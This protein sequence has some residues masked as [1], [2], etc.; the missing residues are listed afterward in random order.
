[1]VNQTRFSRT[2]EVLY[3]C[4]YNL[5]SRPTE[6]KKRESAIDLIWILSGFL[7]VGFIF[8]FFS[9]Y[10]FVFDE[11]IHLKKSTLLYA[12]GLA[13]LII[14]RIVISKIFKDTEVVNV[15]TFHKI[16][17]Y[18]LPVIVIGFMVLSGVKYGN[19]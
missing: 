5:C 18:S 19:Q 1:M 6:K 4:S 14:L 12:T 3:S 13:L 17:V 8:N 15:K 16:I 2:K 11:K 7:I 10:L 9:L